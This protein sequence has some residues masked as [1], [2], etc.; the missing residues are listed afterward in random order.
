MERHAILVFKGLVRGD[1]PKTYMSKRNLDGPFA[2]IQ[3]RVRIL[4][5]ACY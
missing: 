2:Q 1:K 5:C 3:R 4:A